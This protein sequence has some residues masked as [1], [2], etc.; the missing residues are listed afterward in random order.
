MHELHHRHNVC[1]ELK[2]ARDYILQQAANIDVV[3]AIT[4]HLPIVFRP[5]GEVPVLLSTVDNANVI[6]NH[7]EVTMLAAA[8]THTGI[9]FT[10]EKMAVLEREW[11]K[12]KRTSM[13]AAKRVSLTDGDEARLAHEA[14]LL[15]LHSLMWVINC[16]AAETPE[17][18]AAS[19]A[20]SAE[21]TSGG[22]GVEAHVA[23]TATAPEPKTKRQKCD[24]GRLEE[25]IE[26]GRTRGPP[27]PTLLTGIVR[28]VSSKH[29]RAAAQG[30]LEM[31]K[32]KL[33]PFSTV[34]TD[35]E[36]YP[37]LA[38]SFFTNKEVL[39]RTL[40]A[41]HTQPAR[42]TNSMTAPA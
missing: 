11:P 13:T 7:K 40:T 14:M 10:P 27:N 23:A 6:R 22:P 31:Q 8:V 28:D 5:E 2:Q 12:L 1:G 42:P 35:H 4:K 36:F 26:A 29:H 37:A 33:L 18:T 20:A 3:K 9:T 32:V 25:D 21:G 17:G 41:T 16:L 30:L 38:Q 15:D 34:M 19:G 39:P 24:A